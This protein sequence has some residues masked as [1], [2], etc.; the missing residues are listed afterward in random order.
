MLEPPDPDDRYL[1]AKKTHEGKMPVKPLWLSL[2]PQD[3]APDLTPKS[4][5][6]GALP[7][8]MN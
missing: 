7:Y 2:R 5:L 1:G 6:S 8:G 3:E 4:V